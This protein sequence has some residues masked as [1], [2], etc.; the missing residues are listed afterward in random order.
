MR[1]RSFI[2]ALVEVAPPH[3]ARGRVQRTEVM[4]KEDKRDKELQRTQNCMGAAGGIV[5]PTMG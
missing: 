5:G 1:V 4:F 2:A 3:L